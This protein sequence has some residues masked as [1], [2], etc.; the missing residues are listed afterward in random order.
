VLKTTRTNPPT[1]PSDPQPPG[2]TDLFESLVRLLADPTLTAI[3]L[4]FAA[5]LCVAAAT[6]PAAAAAVAA[7][8]PVV[9]KV[10]RLAAAAAADDY[11]P[12]MD[13][14][15]ARKT[16][17]VG[18]LVEVSPANLACAFLGDLRHAGLEAQQV[19]VLQQHCLL[20]LIKLLLG[21]APR[22]YVEERSI[23]AAAIGYLLAGETAMLA[24]MRLG[25]QQ[26]LRTLAKALADDVDDAAVC[27]TSALFHCMQTGTEVAEALVAEP[28]A[29]PR[30]LQ[31][32]AGAVSVRGGVGG[33]GGTVGMVVWGWQLL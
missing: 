11:P 28:G 6:T 29:I 7:F 12:G 8:G 4:L 17:E 9:G 32:H 1:H 26:M 22:R 27:S 31:M 24:G 3:V 10:L 13:R 25:G 15:A 14:A 19:E 20:P 2:R 21:A 30:L 33:W 16:L 5:D 18:V 23:A